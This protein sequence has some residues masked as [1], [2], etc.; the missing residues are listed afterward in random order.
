MILEDRLRDGGIKD[1]QH[2]ETLLAWAK[3]CEQHN[4]LWSELEVV[5]QLLE[6]DLPLQYLICGIP[7]LDVSTPDVPPAV[8]ISLM[9]PDAS[10]ECVMEDP[11]R[12]EWL[13]QTI[14]QLGIP[15]FVVHRSWPEKR[16][17][18]EVISRDTRKPIEILRRYR[19]YSDMGG[20]RY[21]VRPTNEGHRPGGPLVQTISLG[22]HCHVLHYIGVP[23]EAGV[24][25]IQATGRLLIERIAKCGVPD[26]EKF[27]R[28]AGPAL[29]SDIWIEARELYQDSPLANWLRAWN[30]LILKRDT[31]QE[32]ST[33]F[34]AVSEGGRLL[35]KSR[36]ED[37]GWFTIEAKPW[38]D[39]YFPKAMASLA[40]GLGLKVR[41]TGENWE[42]VLDG[43]PIRA[44]MTTGTCVEIGAETEAVRDQ[45]FLGLQRTRC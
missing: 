22:P 4:P 45:L 36:W 33:G 6:V 41:G 2:V 5:R 25:E 27:A 9:R 37:N 7:V 38:E 28:D 21:I 34:Q 31:P 40:W 15:N 17:Y 10:I 14:A 19:R 8:V 3:A 35:S 44:R 1:K 18:L 26:Y 13:E 23:I 42:F 20:R 32:L 24:A 39:D 43:V 12:A 30:L 11:A 16:Y 29:E